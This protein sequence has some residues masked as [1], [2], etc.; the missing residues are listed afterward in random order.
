M[1]LHLAELSTQVAP[2]SHAVVLMDGAGWHRTGG[3]LSVPDNV[4]PLPLP[5]HSPESNGAAAIWAWLRANRL[6]HRVWNSREAIVDDCCSAWNDFVRVPQR[7]ASVT[8]RPW[9][10][11]NG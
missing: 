8:G 7:V 3:R 1:T 2:G 4:T 6:S 9:A 5:P 10:S 11:V